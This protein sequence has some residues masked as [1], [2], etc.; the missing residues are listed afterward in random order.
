M[1]LISEWLVGGVRFE[2]TLETAASMGG[3]GLEVTLGGITSMG[4]VGSGILSEAAESRCSN[5][6][7]FFLDKN[8][9]TI[10]SMIR[11]G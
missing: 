5:A 3:V 9:F 10:S 2:A 4:G 6:I 8:L 1:V 11:L 7:S